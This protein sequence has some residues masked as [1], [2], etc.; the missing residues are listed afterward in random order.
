MNFKIVSDPF[1]PGVAWAREAVN[2][3]QKLLPA[4]SKMPTKFSDKPNYRRWAQ[5]FE[6]ISQAQEAALLHVI[7]QTSVLTG[8]EL[9][10][11]FLKLCQKYNQ[12]YLS[13]GISPIR[14][15][16]D[17][18]LY[19]VSNVFGDSGLPW[20]NYFDLCRNE[21]DS[22][23]F[24]FAKTAP[25]ISDQV[26]GVLF[27]QLP[28][29]A[30]S[31]KN[32]KFNGIEDVVKKCSPGS[33]HVKQHPYSKVKY[34]KSIHKSISSYQL[35]W[36]YPELTYY[37]FSSSLYYE[38]K[39]FGV[40]VRNVHAYYDSYRDLGIRYHYDQRA[41]HRSIADINRAALSEKTLEE[42]LKVK[43]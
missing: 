24:D 36:H 8:W 3:T 16:S 25:M 35:L 7:D 4:A 26:H 37:T 32:A 15:L 34:L 12:P 19:T 31:I 13:F 28:L 20:P 11:G 22:T 39:L 14:C 5:N 17:K 1:R 29:D 41:I 38:A 9:S 43:W 33:F 42:I 23:K 18:H 10:P 27:E 2:K 40:D 6:L 30:A 21:F